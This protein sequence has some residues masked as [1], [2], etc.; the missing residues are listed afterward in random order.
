MSLKPGHWNSHYPPAR[1]EHDI[2]IE[3]ANLD[4]VLEWCQREFDDY[5]T[6]MH[7]TTYYNRIHFVFYCNQDYVAFLLRWA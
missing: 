7:Y 4:K 3:F 1:W 5:E 2:P 6:C